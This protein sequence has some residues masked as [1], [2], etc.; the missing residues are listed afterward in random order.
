MGAGRRDQRAESARPHADWTGPGPTLHK[1]DLTYHP[2]ANFLPDGHRLL[3]Q[4]S[5]PGH[6]NRIY[7]QDLDG[8][9]RP[10]SP[11]G[12]QFGRWRA[13]SP[14]G[15][16]IAALGA[17][18]RITI[19]TIESQHSATFSRLEPDELPIGWNADGRSLYVA[20]AAGVPARIHLVDV[21]TGQRSLWKTFDGPDPAGVLRMGPFF[22]SED[23]KSYVYGYRREV[24]DLFLVEGLK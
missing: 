10:I 7:V 3:V 21:E 20:P 14:D 18:R 9:P 2:N 1:A 13:I 23:G 16:R 12:V 19:Y 17:D 8:A 4:G 11:E 22:I 5:E 15:K 24:G 6:G